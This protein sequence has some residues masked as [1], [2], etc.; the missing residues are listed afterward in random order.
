MP[1]PKMTQSMPN[2]SIIMQSNTGAQST[3]YLSED[4]PEQDMTWWDRQ[5][6]SDND[7]DDVGGE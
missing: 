1:I 4:S 2:A 3:P 5:I 7:A 6:G